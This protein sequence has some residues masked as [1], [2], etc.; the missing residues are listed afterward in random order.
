MTGFYRGKEDVKNEL[1]LEMPI[2]VLLKD[3][4]EAVHTALTT[5][6]WIALREL[7]K[8]LSISIRS[9]QIILSDSLYV[10]KISINW[11]LECK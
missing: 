7:A 4:I 10:K 8:T 6:R 3:K 2:E 1:S 5:D 11:S 9:R